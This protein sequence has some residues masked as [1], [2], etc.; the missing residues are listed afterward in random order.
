MPARKPDA[1]DMLDLP[2]VPRIFLCR[3]TAHPADSR[4][5]LV[6]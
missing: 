6:P 1:F 5:R 2:D 4:L 3:R